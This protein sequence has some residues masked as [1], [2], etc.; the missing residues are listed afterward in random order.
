[1]LAILQSLTM[2]EE[3]CQECQR[4]NFSQSYNLKSP[5]NLSFSSSLKTR[6]SQPVEGCD[7]L[8]V[9][10]LI[11]VFRSVFEVNNFFG[12]VVY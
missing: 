7:I 9:V 1:M 10:E 3:K 8:W 11:A 12:F 5:C 4:A 2:I 6:M